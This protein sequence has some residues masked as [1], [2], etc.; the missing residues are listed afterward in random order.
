MSGT[1]SDPS[2]N[3]GKTEGPGLSS[4]SEGELASRFD[5][6]EGRL[7]AHRKDV[8]AER[9][10]SSGG[11]RSGYARA[12][13]LGSE[14]IAGIVVGAGL[15]WLIDR[16]LGTLPWGLI[17]FLMIGFAAGVLNV[18]RSEGMLTPA[19]IRRKGDTPDERN[20]SSGSR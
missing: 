6:L 1:Q 14:F 11:D 2:D 15:G 9:K 12:V 16:S 4:L 20:G 7:K 17:I 5:G 10:A 3:G 8:E 18:M 13:K 19:G